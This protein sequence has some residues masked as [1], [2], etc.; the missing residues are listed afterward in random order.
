MNCSYYEY[1]FI[2][3]VYNT[4]KYFGKC[5]ESILKQ[6]ECCELI[7]VDDGSTDS[8]GNICDFYARQHERI[9]VF[10]NKN[11]GPGAARNFG[12]DKAS[13]NYIIFV[14]SDDY[15]SNGLIKYLDRGYAD[16]SADL[17]FFNIIK[18][19]SDG[20]LEPMAEGL[21]KD[22][23]Y[24]KP[25]NEVLK[26]ISEC[27]KFPASIGGKIIKRDVLIKNN[28]RFEEGIAGEDI[29]WTLQLICSINSADV[30]PEESYYYRISSGTRRSYGSVKSMCDYLGVLEEWTEKAK[31]KTTQKNKYILSFLSYQYAVF[32]PFY[33]SLPTEERVPYTKRIKKLRFLLSYGKTK[34]IKLIRLA[35]GLLG[36]NG[37]SKLLYRYV[38]KRDEANA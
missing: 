28:I 38:M 24:G 19:F 22:K 26:A 20:R 13:G 33:G 17:I 12:L 29:G 7:L 5:I 8:S 23:I 14:D 34:K 37:A 35:V 2:V 11:S 18:K 31:E 10:H 4:E 30:Y 27:S 21:K 1:S 6:G 3:P 15:V 32:L 25:M 16:R 36:I 9:K